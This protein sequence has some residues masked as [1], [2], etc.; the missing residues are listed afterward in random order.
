MIIEDFPSEGKDLTKMVK[1]MGYSIVGVNRRE[2]ISRIKNLHDYE[3]L[4]AVQRSNTDYSL[5]KSHIQV[6]TSEFLW[7]NSIQV[8]IVKHMSNSLLT[9]ESIAYEHAISVR[10]LSRK[11]KKLTNSNTTE[12]IREVRLRK[13]LE[14][15]ESGVCSSVKA[16]SHTVGYH[17]QKYFSKI[18]RNKFKVSPSELIKREAECLL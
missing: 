17:D 11:L 15:I 1:T 8:Y 7:L 2:S 13:A 6:P 10:H 5:L 16:V 3:C 14:Y 12:Y 4:W 18:F 9:A